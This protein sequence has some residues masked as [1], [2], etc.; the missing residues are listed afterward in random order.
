MM[1]VSNPRAFLAVA[2][3]VLALSGCGGGSAGVAPKDQPAGQNTGLGPGPSGLTAVYGLSPSAASYELPFPRGYDG[4]TTLGANGAPAGAKLTLNI[5]EAGL[6]AGAPATTGDPFPLLIT[7]EVPVTIT[8]SEP[9]CVIDLA[10]AACGPGTFD[11]TF[12]DP[13]KA[14]DALTNPR[15]L[16]LAMLNGSV[17]T[18]RPPAGATLKFVG[19]V[20][21]TF[22]FSR[23]ISDA[24][25]EAA[26]SVLFPVQ[27]N[28]Q[29]SLADVG[30]LGADVKY[31]ARGS[32]F[33]QW[34]TISGSP[35][36]VQQLT[37]GNKPSESV[38]VSGT[39]P[40][41]LTSVTVTSDFSNKGTRKKS[42]ARGGPGTFVPDA[43]PIVLGPFPATLSHKRAAFT[44]VSS[45]GLAVEA[46]KAWDFGTIAVTACVPK[47]V[48]QPCGLPGSTNVL[49]SVP[50][51]TQFHVLVGDFSGLLTAAYSIAVTAPCSAADIN[52]NDNDG[53]APSGY[54][55][56][57]T[58]PN[59]EF[60]LLSGASAGTCTITASYNGSPVA[61][62]QIT[63]GSAASAS[64][65][66]VPFALRPPVNA[67][68]GF[69]VSGKIQ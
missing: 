65:A 49:T 38:V 24:Y 11:V 66:A 39:G 62:T 25:P 10:Q 53:D 8:I 13:T 46:H 23:D 27:S 61:Q 37:H 33:L 68:A 3:S 14:P 63:V 48:H 51:N 52:Q 55:D 40:V 28:T 19:G 47:D 18:F 9:T 2:L 12:F 1:G 59:A 17:L 26:A 43:T 31:Q 6:T 60:T 34:Q 16:G 57:P 5:A 56:N 54:N 21:Y 50:T 42:K 32:G 44:V 20:Q 29:Q 15:P 30:P 64:S 58:G 45:S 35:A 67:P 69:A 22:I 36:G 4:T 41:T 7:F